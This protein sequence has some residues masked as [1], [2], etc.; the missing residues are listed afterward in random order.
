MVAHMN[1]KQTRYRRS[2]SS[3]QSGSVMMESIFVIPTLLV[4]GLGVFEFGNFFYQRHLI[5]AG[6][7]DAARYIASFPKGSTAEE[8]DAKEIALTGEIGGSNYRVSYW[9]DKSTIQF[10]HA[11]ANAGGISYNGDTI[12]LRNSYTAGGNVVVDKVEARAQVPYQSLGFLT[13]FFGLGNLT[14][15][16]SHEERLIGN[17]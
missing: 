3:D 13:G 15:R 7:R 8:D 14:I 12:S 2:L 10:V 1:T 4:I 5:E 9:Q 11:T 17:R 6:V 16:V